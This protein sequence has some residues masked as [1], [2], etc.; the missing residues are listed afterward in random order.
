MKVRKREHITPVLA[1]L[2]WLPIEYR[3]QY[4]IIVYTYKAI[5]KTGPTYL[6]ELV[7]SYCPS[8][9]LRSEHAMQLEVPRTRTRLYGGRRFDASASTLWNSLPIS[10]KQ[11]KTL[12]TFKRDLKTHLFK[13]AYFTT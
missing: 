1:K 3:V 12:N 9:S 7:K 10:L 11:A 4:K 13:L 6:S 8:R 5:H 2:H